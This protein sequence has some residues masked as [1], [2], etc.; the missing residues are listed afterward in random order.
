[1]WNFKLHLALTNVFCTFHT[2]NNLRTLIFLICFSLVPDAASADWNVCTLNVI[3][4][5]SL[6]LALCPP[7]FD[8]A[9]QLFIIPDT[10]LMWH[11]CDRPVIQ[12]KCHVTKEIWSDCAVSFILCL[13]AVLCCYSESWA[14]FNI[15]LLYS[16][17]I[18]EN[19]SVQHTWYLF[20]VPTATHFSFLN[21][22]V[23]WLYKN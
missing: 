17:F 1:M 11:F 22:T 5:P 21:K 15:C 8:R 2:L 10:V 18:K 23:I 16:T 4:W 3:S 13:L 20:I 9:R 12:T 7:T 14:S 19:I 6:W